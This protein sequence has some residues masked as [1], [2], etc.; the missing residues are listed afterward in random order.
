VAN[1]DVHRLFLLMRICGIHACVGSRR[2]ADSMSLSSRESLDST[3]NF[4]RTL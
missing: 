2:P 1:N 4:L 3:S